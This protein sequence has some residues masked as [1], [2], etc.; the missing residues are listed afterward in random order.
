MEGLL[1][2]PWVDEGGEEPGSAPAGGYTV[3]PVVTD[4][5]TSFEVFVGAQ[6]NRGEAAYRP[7]PTT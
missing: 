6:R 1:L 3:T 7:P 4:D 5:G 2:E